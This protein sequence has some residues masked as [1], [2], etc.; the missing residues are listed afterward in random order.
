[1]D[2]MQIR[3][4]NKKGVK[5]IYPNFHVDIATKD[6]MI[7]GG[8]FY[9]FWDEKNNI[10]SKN[11]LL[12]AT[13]I[14]E[15]LDE[16]FREELDKDQGMA[17]KV[18]H[19]CD[20]VDGR[21]AAW[22]SYIRNIPD[23]CKGELDGKIL[24]EDHEIVREDF[25]TKKLPYRLTNE[26]TPEYDEL[27]ST[28][29]SPEERKKIEWAIGSVIAGDSVDIQK[30]IVFY[31]SAGSGKSTVLN[32]IQKLFEG[33]Y[34]VFE[35]KV[36]GYSNASFST[37]QLKENPLV[38]IE[39]DGDLSKIEDNS[40]LNSIVSHERMT[41]NE[42]FKSMY[43]M[44]FRS[45][46]FIG[47]NRPVKITDAKSGLMRRL[48]D[49]QPTGNTL[50]IGKYRMIM[51]KIE[52]QLG[53]IANRCLKVYKTLGKSYFDNYKPLAMMWQT[54][55]FYNFMEDNFSVFKKQ[56]YIELNQIWLM[57]KEYCEDAKV[58]FPFSKRLV[59]A[60]LVNYFATFDSDVYLKTDDGNRVH[61]TNV[62]SGFLID[63]FRHKPKKD[64]EID[65]ISW[66]DLSATKSLLDKEL[67]D[68]PAQYANEEGTPK[69]KWENV[70]TT[71][72]SINTKKLHY[73][74]VPENHIVID[75][76]ISENGE[77]NLERNI[78]AAEKFPQ[79]YAE[80]SKSQSGLHLHYIYDGD[81]SKL[82]RVYDDNIEIKVFTG[83]SSLRRKLSVC[84]NIPVAHISSGLPLKGGDEKVI[85]FEGLKNEKALRTLIKRNLNKEI[86]G[87]T[88]PSVDFIKKI[89][90]DAY[91]GGMC[92]DVTDMRPAIMAFAAN[93]T[94]Q[95]QNCLN[96]VAQ[97]HFHSDEPSETDEYDNDMLIFYDVE[98]FPNLFIV[99]WKAE[100][101]APV[102]MI[103]PTPSE[104]EE[105]VKFKLV[106]F[107]CRR[108]D[109]HILYARMLGYDNHQLYEL[110]QRIIN[111]SMNAMFGE[112]YNIS[113]TDVY[114]FSSKKQSL[115][116]F[117]IELGMHHQELGL[118]WDQPVDET[119]W[120]TVAEYCVND[121]VSTEATFKARYDDFVAR[122]ILASI[123][124]LTVN[125]TNN[126]HTAKM[127]FG[128]DPHPQDQFIYT[129][130]SEYFEGYT[131]SE[132]KSFYRDEDPGEGGYV[133]SEPGMYENVA[134]LDIASMHPHSIIALNMFGNKYTAKFKELVDARIFIKHGEFDKAG[135][136]FDGKL[137]P[138]L[139][140]ANQAKTLS[141]ALKIPINSVYGL[142]S[143]KFD[144][145]F[146]D[147]R[148]VDNIVA[149]RGALFMIDLKHEVQ[150]RGFTVAHIKTDSIKIPNATP[151]IIKFIIDYGEKWNYTFEHEATYSKM[152]LVNDA[153]Y[154]AKE[155]DKWTATGKQFQ[156]PY[157]FKTLFSHEEIEFNDLCETKAVSGDAALYLDFNEVDEETH[158]Y[159]FV[160]R[161]GSFCPV[162][163]GSNGGLLLRGSKDKNGEDRYT[164][165]T[166][167]K[168]YRWKEAEVVKELHQEDQIDKEYFRKLVDDAVDTISQF[169]DFD[170]FVGR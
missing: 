101:K 135:E 141:N 80:V 22:K 82:S 99:V 69:K 49:V 145:K 52:F 114:D 55:D 118:P 4:V 152:C 137:K 157:V 10:W 18:E 95:A 7:R 127:I 31:G 155:N 64:E 140:D 78:N 162:K 51:Q 92:Y 168:D 41:V 63:K 61:M 16:R 29:Y 109:N 138:F 77:K 67:S 146:R 116:K 151:E 136:L 122:E 117:E 129:D 104:I 73:V 84:N 83:N 3:V 161:V 60:E 50:P 25:A 47:T 38:A 98:V 108:Y 32:I 1:M 149:K 19:M 91:E 167:A 134:L 79:T 160:G 23:N 62:Y 147:N 90:D 70:S 75:F 57:Y 6:I 148:N 87:A 15:M 71:L 158:D 36:L 85:K 113:Y 26:Q 53:G 88:K 131:F 59:K 76:D 107:N 86:H 96:M 72:S 156:V 44:K 24:F 124:G 58:R 56:D 150:K 68:C 142:T 128:N 34:S 121:V 46:L 27:M 39:H 166:G 115:K 159:R 143:A 42:K 81:V 9:A 17:I 125:N 103:N 163:R 35:S 13:R 40:K 126:Q 30:F 100:D 169:C 139:K 43:T 170:Q 11:E 164:F 54:N 66:L 45:M 37:S 102:K 94:N 65:Y 8:A 12:M 28:L 14:D 48:I 74:M 119:L 153:V 33:Y 105:L 144:N 133:Y 111:G 120:D 106:G 123:S 110:S 93:S 5:T 112:A 130:L 21:L 97:M 2:F 132:G 165:A 20:S 154:I 89:L